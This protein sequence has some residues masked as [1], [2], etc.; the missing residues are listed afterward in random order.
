MTRSDVIR[1]VIGAAGFESPDLRQDCLSSH[2][3][4]LHIP[5][6]IRQDIIAVLTPIE[7]AGNLPAV[8]CYALWN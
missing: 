6:H 5:H 8:T 7:Q 2:F 3:K 4:W 1:E